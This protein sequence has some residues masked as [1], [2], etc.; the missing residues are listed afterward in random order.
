MVRPRTVSNEEVLQGI[1]YLQDELDLEYF[2]SERLGEE[3]RLSRP[4]VNRRIKELEA[5]GW[6]R[7]KRYRNQKGHWRYQVR[8]MSKGRKAIS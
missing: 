3:V 8:V 6:I 5:L 1:V 4:T 2:T 7:V